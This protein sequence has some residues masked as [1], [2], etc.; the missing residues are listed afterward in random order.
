LNDGL[1]EGDYK[2][3][4]N[5]G[6]IKEFH[7]YKKNKRIDSS[8][9]YYKP[10]SSNNIKQITYWS[11]STYYEKFYTEKGIEVKEGSSNNSSNYKT[12][13]YITKKENL[14]VLLNI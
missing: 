10:N 6:G 5:S 13:N 1:T 4:F 8:I 2:V 3:Y 9:Y 12:G 14:I 7:V 11:D